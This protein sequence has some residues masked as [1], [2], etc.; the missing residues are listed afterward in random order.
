[1]AVA[2]KV[3]RGC[4]SRFSI[5]DPIL[6]TRKL[7]LLLGAGRPVAFSAG[8]RCDGTTGMK[9]GLETGFEANLSS[10]EGGEARSTTVISPAAWARYSATSIG[11]C[12]FS[13]NAR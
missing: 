8:R 6:T 2:T 4:H 11:R 3:D 1:M 9:G 13:T 7:Q 5:L 10:R 12:F